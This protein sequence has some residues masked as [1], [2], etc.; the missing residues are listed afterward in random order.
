MANLSKAPC[1]LFSIRRPPFSGATGK[2]NLGNATPGVT[3]QT[4]WRDSLYRGQAGGEVVSRLRR[5][6]SFRNLIKSKRNQIVFTIFQL[7]WNQSEFRLDQNLS[8]KG[9]YNLIPIDLTKIKI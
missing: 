4:R 2:T 1:R 5:E 8:V 3:G 7:I 9:K 6:K